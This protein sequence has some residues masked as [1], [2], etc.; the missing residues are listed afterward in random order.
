VTTHVALEDRAPEVPPCDALAEAVVLSYVL[1]HA[2]Q[3]AL[4]CDLLPLLVF[5]EHREI[6]Q[7]M[8]RVYRADESHERFYLRWLNEVERVRPGLSEVLLSIG[9]SWSRWQHKRLERDPLCRS[10]STL[11]F[12]WWYARLQQVARARRLIEDAQRVAEC[13]WRGDVDGA[14]EVVG[15]IDHGR[16]AVA[17]WDRAP[18]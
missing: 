6:W 11:D 3:K 4:E 17:I 16:G 8:R 9:D 12:D 14:I 10:V 1:H 2:P 15:A 13:A 7:A 18:L 5:P